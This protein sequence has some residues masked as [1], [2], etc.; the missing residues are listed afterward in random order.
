MLYRALG[1]YQQ[2]TA[3]V[4]LINRFDGKRIFE[5]LM[6]KLDSLARVLTQW[7]STE[8]LQVQ[9]LLLI[10]AAFASALIPLLQGGLPAGNLAVA[11]AHPAFALMWLVG[12][13]CA[14]GAATQAKY[15]RLAAL[16]LAGGAGL[17]HLHDVRLVFGTR[18]GVDATR[19][20]D[21]DACP[22][23]AWLALASAAF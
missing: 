20:G 12:A 21:G 18:P 6:E 3:V 15:H 19:G 8:R 16:S 1:K 2:G 11:A 4:P 7:L 13:A 14:I 17:G 23:P 10:C 5:F 9:L 22:D